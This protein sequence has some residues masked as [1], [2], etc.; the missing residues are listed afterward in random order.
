M[1]RVL[2]SST[3]RARGARALSSAAAGQQY[4]SVKVSVGDVSLHAVVPADESAL[5]DKPRVLCLPSGFG[6][7]CRASCLPSS[8]DWWLDV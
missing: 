3:L 6:E 1:L 5:A 2:A 4:R 8:S 7:L